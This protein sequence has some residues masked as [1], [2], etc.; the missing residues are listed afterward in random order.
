MIISM[1]LTSLIQFEKIVL[2]LIVFKN[3]VITAYYKGFDRSQLLLLDC[4]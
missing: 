3:S 4:C 1:S 2:T